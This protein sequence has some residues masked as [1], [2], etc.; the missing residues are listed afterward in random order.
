MAFYLSHTE[1]L[2]VKAPPA[3]F[4]VLA[5]PTS[6]TAAAGAAGSTASG[7]N[8]GLVGGS[9]ASSDTVLLSRLSGGEA[10]MAEGP[11]L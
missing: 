8:E 11:R 1:H 10:S 6:E 3:G 2:Y 4:V 5:R 7:Q 9:S